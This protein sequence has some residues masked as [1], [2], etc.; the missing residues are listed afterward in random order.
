MTENNMI[1]DAEYLVFGIKKNRMT[2]EPEVDRQSAAVFART[3]VDGEERLFATKRHAEGLD[4]VA[5]GEEEEQ[6]LRK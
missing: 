4:F 6:D 2:G 5:L 1:L 3:V